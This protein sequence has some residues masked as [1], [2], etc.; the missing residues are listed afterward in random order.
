MPTYT[1]ACDICGLEKDIFRTVSEHGT[2]PKHCGTKMR[3]VL[4]PPQIMADIQPFRAPVIDITTGKRADIR[5]RNQ[6]KE[7]ERQ[8]H[9]HQIGDDVRPR[10]TITGPEGL[11]SDLHSAVQQAKAKHG[12]RF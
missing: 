6:L 8:N 4:Q 11:K 3:Q 10:K 9:C 7:F 5:S 1:I 2:W 12:R